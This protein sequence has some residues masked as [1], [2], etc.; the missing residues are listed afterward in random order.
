MVCDFQ[1]QFILHQD[2]QQNTQQLQTEAVQYVQQKVAAATLPVAVKKEP[3][4]KPPVG[5]V[6]FVTLG[7]MMLAEFRTSDD[8]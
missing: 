1:V 2:L 7:D 5:K 3:D 8:C 4:V 6:S